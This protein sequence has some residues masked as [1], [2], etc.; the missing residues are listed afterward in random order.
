MSV[1][2]YEMLLIALEANGS[3]Y[4]YKP[5]TYCKRVACLQKRQ[6]FQAAS[7]FCID[8]FGFAYN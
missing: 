2:E 5:V 1:T 6:H 8:I 7:V 3:N 4:H